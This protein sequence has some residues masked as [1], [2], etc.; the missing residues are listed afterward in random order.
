MHYGHVFM[1]TQIL[2]SAVSGCISWLGELSSTSDSRLLRPSLSPPFRLRAAS[3]PPPTWPL[4]PFLPAFPSGSQRA[5][6]WAFAVPPSHLWIPFLHFLLALSA[7]L[8][9]M[10]SFNF[11][12]SGTCPSISVSNPCLFRRVS[13]EFPVFCWTFSPTCST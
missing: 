4:T 11:H 13:L 7:D 2:C 9:H 5:I 8:T 10:H 6:I 3:H 12:L 1:S